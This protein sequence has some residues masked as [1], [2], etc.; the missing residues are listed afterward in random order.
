MQIDDAI[1]LA[2]VVISSSDGESLVQV[3]AIPRK[4]Q[5]FRDSPASQVREMLKVWPAVAV[6]MTKAVQDRVDDNPFQH[7]IPC[8]FDNGTSQQGRQNKH[9]ERAANSVRY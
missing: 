2:F 6:N 8:P 3:H 1:P 4:G 9:E 7:F 5:N